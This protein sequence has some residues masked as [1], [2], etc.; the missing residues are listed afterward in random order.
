MESK[1]KFDFRCE[2]SHPTMPIKKAK[3]RQNKK[4]LKCANHAGMPPYK[5]RLM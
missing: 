3:K 4:V 5:L 2:E 1:K